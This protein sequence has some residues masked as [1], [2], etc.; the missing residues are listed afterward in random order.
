[1]QTE[2]AL[3]HSRVHQYTLNTERIENKLDKYAL[4]VSKLP[5]RIIDLEE[6]KADWVIV[7]DKLAALWEAISKTNKQVDSLHI[8]IGVQEK[9]VDS[10]IP[11]RT[12]YQISETLQVCL[13][14]VYLDRL[15]NF[16]IGKYRELNENL[17]SIE[18][19]N[20]Q[21]TMAQTLDRLKN[22]LEYYVK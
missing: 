14:R 12:Q 15:D 18:H 7:E 17:L 2:C 3:L 1:M 9:Y 6:N 8:K 5:P 21:D 10:Y 16:E 22:L 4:D 19:T 20:I 13:P 11:I